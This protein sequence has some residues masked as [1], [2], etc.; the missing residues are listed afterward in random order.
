MI[1][2]PAFAIPGLS[3]E[4]LGDTCDP[5]FLLALAD[6]ALDSPGVAVEGVASGVTAG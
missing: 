4:E 3:A 2:N 6:A 5:S 1:P